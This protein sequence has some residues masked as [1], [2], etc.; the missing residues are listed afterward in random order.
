MTE[1]EY[2]TTKRMTLASNVLQDA[3]DI[4]VISFDPPTKEG[5][6]GLLVVRCPSE[7]DYR[8]V[9]R[10]LD[11]ERGSA[12]K[13]MNGGVWYIH[14]VAGDAQ[15]GQPFPQHINFRVEWRFR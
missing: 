13:S 1:P 7:D 3:R 9:L 8:G 10:F 12:L 11:E 6:E 14:R 2:V 4:Q 15:S 5:R